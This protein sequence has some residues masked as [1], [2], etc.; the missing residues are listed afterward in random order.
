VHFSQ[1]ALNHSLSHEG[2][3]AWWTNRK[4]LNQA[5]V[6]HKLGRLPEA[7][8]LMHE[9]QENMSR[10]DHPDDDDSQLIGEV[11]ELLRSIEENP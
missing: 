4:R 2:S 3:D 9:L 5:R 6:L 10:K 1:Q 8:V 11:A 7:M